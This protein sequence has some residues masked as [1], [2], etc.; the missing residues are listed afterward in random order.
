MQH[1]QSPLLKD[2]ASLV[3]YARQYSAYYSNLYRN[4]PQ[5]G[6]QLCDL[7]LIDAGDYWQ[8]PQGL[9]A[10]PVLT[11]PI[12]G[13]HLFK[14]GGT[15]G[16]GKVSVYTREEWRSFVATF[17]RGLSTLL[18]PGDRVAN[19]FFA[20]DLYASLLFIHGA[21][22]HTEVPVCEYPFAGAVAPE[23]LANAVRAYDLNVLASVPAQLLRIASYLA[24]RGETLLQPRAILYGGESLFAEQLALL[25]QVFPNARCRSIGYASVDG[26]LLGASTLDCQ[27]GEHRCFD[28][29]T[30]IEIIDEETSL[31]IEEAGRSGMLVL[32]SMQRRLMPLIRYPSG[33]LAS[34]VEAPGTPQR[35]F[36]LQGRSSLGHRVRVGSFI[37]I[38]PNDI[39]ASIHQ[40]VGACSWQLQIDHINGTDLLTIRLAQPTDAS[41]LDELRS[42]LLAQHSGMVGLIDEGRMQLAFEICDNAGLTLHPRTGKLPRV[43]DRRNYQ[44]EETA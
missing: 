37:S 2:L 16:S 40:H 44:A 36:V 26:G 21:L 5:N 15:T 42:S 19:L 39:E 3:R 13:A 43:L 4:L 8:M 1:S 20:G 14:T 41:A 12:A 9:H 33:D 35:K 29:D 27:L 6:W 34:W 25:K 17:G 28:R 18:Q 22:A 10:W 32:T 11:G 31:P 7:P 23:T 24:Q 38:F 30:I